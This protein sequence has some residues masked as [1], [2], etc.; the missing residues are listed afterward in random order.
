[1]M[2]GRARNR[3]VA[4]RLAFAEDATMA[5]SSTVLLAPPNSAI[6]NGCVQN[7][8][9][10]ADVAVAEIAMS[11]R[12]L[13]DS[14][15]ISC[16]DPPA[17]SASALSS[18]VAVE[19]EIKKPSARLRT[20][21]RSRKNLAQKLS[22]MLDY[23]NPV[24]LNPTTAM[25]S[26]DDQIPATMAGIFRV[27]ALTRIQAALLQKKFAA[28]AT[29]EKKPVTSSST[30]DRHGRSESN[31]QKSSQEFLVAERTSSASVEE[32][33]ALE[34][35]LASISTTAIDIRLNAADMA[36]TMQE[37]A[38]NCAQESI[39][40]SKGKSNHKQVAWTLKKE[41]DQMY[42][43]AWHCIVGTD[44]G[45]YVTHSLG[46]FLYFSIGKLSILLFRT[47]VE[48]IN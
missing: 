43:P 36:K 18:S 22:G 2:Y 25:M 14:C 9:S 1:M 10:L 29:E 41:F 17:Q 39:S 33:Q 7:L 24:R 45:S 32:K 46:G 40:N 26:L 27:R 13:E 34:I 19:N 21:S 47:A 37:H 31:S 42:G 3:Y 11:S 8:D 38:L 30:L 6:S 28:L 20:S 5:K 16:S 15:R 48:V 12:K 4:R 35:P 44:F 23:P